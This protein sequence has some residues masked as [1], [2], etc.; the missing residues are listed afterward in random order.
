MRL[1]VIAVLFAAQLPAQTVT[2]KKQDGTNW[3]GTLRPHPRVLISD[4]IDTRIKDPDGDGPLKAPLLSSNPLPPYINAAWKALHLTTVADRKDDRYLAET[5]LYTSLG[6]YMD[7]YASFSGDNRQCTAG[8]LDGTVSDLITDSS[9][10]TYHDCYKWYALDAIKTWPVRRVDSGACFI[11]ATQCGFDPTSYEDL[12][13]YGDNVAYTAFAYSIMRSFLTPAERNAFMANQLNGAMP[14][15]S[16]SPPCVNRIQEHPALNGSFRFSAASKYICTGKYGTTKT[17][18]TATWTGTDRLPDDL[19]GKNIFFAQ[20]SGTATFQDATEVQIPTVGYKSEQT[21]CWNT[22]NVKITP[23]S[24]AYAMGITTVRFSTPMSGSCVTNIE[25]TSRNGSFGVV[26]SVDPANN[27]FTFDSCSGRSGVDNQLF[28]V[29][30]AGPDKCSFSFN[31]VHYGNS[32]AYVNGTFNTSLASDVSPAD[33]TITVREVTGFPTVY[34]YYISIG[35]DRDRELV[36]VL[37]ADGTH[38]TVDRNIYETVA[39]AWPA[40]AVVYWRY[41]SQ[42]MDYNGWNNR[43]LTKQ[44]AFLAQAVAF[45]DDSPLARKLLEEA[46]QFFYANASMAGHKYYGLLTGS[47]ISYGIS[48]VMH[49]WSGLVQTLFTATNGAVDF[50][51]PWM[52]KG[53]ALLYPYLSLPWAPLRIPVVGQT[54]DNC[55]SFIG[56][57]EGNCLEAAVVVQEFA[58]DSAEAK[59]AWKFAMDSGRLTDVNDVKSNNRNI[60]AILLFTD[61]TE[62]GADWMAESPSHFVDNGSNASDPT[63]N[64]SLAISRSSW[65]SDA[66]YSHIMA[67]DGHGDK[68]VDIPMGHYVLGK[69]NDWFIGNASNLPYSWIDL[70]HARNYYDSTEWN[71]NTI[72]I[73]NPRSY[74]KN[75]TS[76][77]IVTMADFS[78]EIDKKK[79]D[80]QPGGGSY[81]Y[82][83]VNSK[84]AL[85]ESRLGLT[86]TRRYR[87][88][89]HFKPT[90]G[91]EHFVVFDDIGTSAPALIRSQIPYNNNGQTSANLPAYG[92]EGWTSLSADGKQVVSTSYTGTHKLTTNILRGGRQ[93]ISDINAEYSGNILRIC[94]DCS[95]DHPSYVIA[96]GKSWSYPSPMSATFAV[97]TGGI[98]YFWVNPADGSFH[99]APKTGY[100]I[101]SCTGPI[102]C[103]APIADWPGGVIRI[104][105]LAT[106]SPCPGA[107]GGTNGTEDYH[108]RGYDD[109]HGVYLGEGYAVTSADFLVT[110]QITPAARAAD[111]VTE[112]TS[113]SPNF[114]GVQITGANP[115]VAVF[116]KGTASGLFNESSF[117][118][119]HTGTAQYLVSGLN[120]GIYD[121]VRD[122]SVLQPGLAVSGSDGAVYFESAKGNFVILQ[123]GT[124][125]PLQITTAELPDATVGQ[126][127]SQTLTASGGATPYSWSLV[128]GTLPTGV[129]LSIGG[130][131]SG[132]PSELGTS[133]FTARVTDSAGTQSTRVL[134]L[135]VAPANSVQ[136]TTTA[137]PRGTAGEA[138]SATLSAINGTPPYVWNLTSGTLPDG[139]S[140]TPSGLIQGLSGSA[141]SSVFTV[142]VRDI[143]GTTDSHTYTLTIDPAIVPLRIV[144]PAT[145]PSIPFSETFSFTLEATGGNPPY[146]WTIPSGDL[147]PGISLTSGAL[148]TLEGTP[149]AVGAYSFTAQVT[150]SASA[151]ASQEFTLVVAGTEPLVLDSKLVPNGFVGQNYSFTLSASGGTPP[152]T[153]SLSGNLPAGLTLDGTS[154][155][156]TG[157][158]QSVTSSQIEVTVTDGS[159]ETVAAT[160]VTSALQYVTPQNLEISPLTRNAVVKYGFPGLLSEVTC[161]VEARGTDAEGQVL[162]TAVDQG[163]PSRRTAVLSNLD[164]A[165]IH[166]VELRCQDFGGRKIFRTRGTDPRLSIAA[167]GRELKVQMAAPP[168]LGATQLRLSY[169]E[170]PGQLVNTTTTPCALKCES[171]ITVTPDSVLYLQPKWLNAQGDILMTGSL[172]VVAVP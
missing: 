79:S 168:G 18:F 3:T 17:P 20:K 35:N 171:L 121:I 132:I 63:T 105:K 23:T 160:F 31:C 158:P 34:P 123:S 156:I 67:P 12:Q 140:L 39:R 28:Y 98:W 97:T 14:P 108:C 59:Y 78:Q 72:I 44:Q 159:G 82:V 5:M 86:V 106:T 115:K 80:D 89:A 143:A 70:S 41:S 10:K 135:K 85:N 92:Q 52:K 9:G 139:L 58:R 30:D 75:G 74:Q 68:W 91:T 157:V 166:S 90:G 116:G 33:T 19:V 65:S 27:T 130:V 126:A 167:G 163:G 40:N 137:V 60:L 1:C 128:S 172:K 110:H 127:Y 122:G 2:L 153:W 21:H 146:V 57:S 141:G 101:T 87:H 161:S 111:A 148:G 16:T 129:S 49:H 53:M 150:D 64:L 134:S 95:P 47:V 77:D 136:I 119:T 151:T 55:R 100:T 124:L 43:D 88:F 125:P 104:A 29:D 69:A 38:L 66:T 109:A 37:S 8:K 117:T 138:Y 6:Y 114:V 32:P 42:T 36:K 48:R 107:F 76:P 96:D 120:P 94:Y 45:A 149:T 73:G 112:L 118:T 133:V 50:R 71:Q 4:A 170:E 22:N 103:E 162:S 131:I 24:V 155:A 145:L 165:T 46:S 7:H 84:D 113:I 83:R 102:S 54:P 25:S 56:S 164:P 61:G 147:P 154:G 169:G 142:S 93:Y 15:S 99:G 62:T 81:L 13:Y 11:V 144:S 51:H 26:R 152:Y